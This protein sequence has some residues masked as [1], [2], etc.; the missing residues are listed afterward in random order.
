MRYIR[1]SV[2]CSIILCSIILCSIYFGAGRKLP[3]DG[4]KWRKESH[5]A[6]AVWLSLGCV[7]DLDARPCQ[8]NLDAHGFCRGYSNPLAMMGVKSF[9]GLLDF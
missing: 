4:R 2:S 9:R 6:D 5:T 3:R 7:A 1:H 8:A